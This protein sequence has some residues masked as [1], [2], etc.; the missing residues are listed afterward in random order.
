MP[1][2]TA[3]ARAVPGP[4]KASP[5]SAF[6]E[7][8]SAAASGAVDPATVV[9]FEMTLASGRAPSTAATSASALA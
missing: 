5:A 2:A 8:P 3:A 6:T 4:D 7:A 1:W 9:T